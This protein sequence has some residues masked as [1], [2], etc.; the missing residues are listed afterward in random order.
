MQGLVSNYTCVPVHRNFCISTRPQ[1]TSG[2]GQ[3]DT[4]PMLALRGG[5]RL[6]PTLYKLR[7]TLFLADRLVYSNNQ[8]ATDGNSNINYCLTFTAYYNG[9]VGGI[10]SH[11]PATWRNICR[12]EQQ[13]QSAWTHQQWKCQLWL[14]IVTLLLHNAINIPYK[15]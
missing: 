8:K 11:P 10:K 3:P 4:S 13:K 15:R 7:K 14:T 9:L 2:H 5:A 12:Q 1:G 6:P